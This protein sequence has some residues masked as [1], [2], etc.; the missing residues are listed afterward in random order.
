MNRCFITDFSESR[1]QSGFSRIYECEFR[2]VSAEFWRIVAN[3][4]VAHPFTD[5][6]TDSG[7]SARRNSFILNEVEMEA[8]VGIGEAQPVLSP[9]NLSGRVQACL[10]RLK[11]TQVRNGSEVRVRVRVL[12]RSQIN[13]SSNPIATGEAKWTP[14]SP[15]FPSCAQLDCRGNGR[16]KCRT[17]LG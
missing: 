17:R 4:S 8:R 16:K 13:C 11:P 5:T 3:C 7:H 12:A 9:G 14:P 15:E 1:N 10:S 2:R 6:F